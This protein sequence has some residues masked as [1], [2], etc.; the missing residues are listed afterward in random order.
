MGTAT[1]S[2]AARQAEQTGA[3][4]RAGEVLL[5]DRCLTVRPAL[6]ELVEVGKDR[7]PQDALER[8]GAKEPVER[9]VRVGVVECVERP[10]QLF[11]EG[12]CRR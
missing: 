11:A 6:A 7:F 10:A 4:E 1:V 12:G 3:E 8:V 5:R 2:P 9:G